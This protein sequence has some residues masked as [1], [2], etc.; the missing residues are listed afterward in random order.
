MQSNI[1]TNTKTSSARIS[2][3]EIQR[4]LKKGRIERSN[5][6]FIYYDGFINTIKSFL[7]QSFSGLNKK[8]QMVTRGNQNLS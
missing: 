8:G 1:Q 3:E 2:Y 4:G 5:T 6:F 7:R